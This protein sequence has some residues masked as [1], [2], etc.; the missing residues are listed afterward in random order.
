MRI[1]ILILT[2]L[3]ASSVLGQSDYK[4]MMNDMQVNFYDVVKE[5]ELY[6]ETH[7]TGKGSG[8]KDYQRW[9][10]DNESKY[11]PS[12]DRSQ[13]DPYFVAN[14]YQDFRK[15]NP[16]PKNFYSNQWR[17]LGPYDANNI[18]SHYSP[19]IGRVECFW[20]NPSDSNH[21]YMG[22]R[23]GG[24]W[25][26]TNE[27]ATWQNTTDFLIASGVYTIAVSP[28]NNDSILIGI[29]NAANNASHG[30]YRSTDGGNTWMVTAFNPTNLGWGGLG[31]NDRIF[32]IVYHP[33]IPNLIF[34]GTSKGIFKSAD[35]LQTWTQLLTSADITDIEFHPTNPDI[36][37]LY[38]DYSSSSNQN[39]VMR[40]TDL[41]LS[42][43]I[44]GTIA[45]NNNAKGFIAVSPLCPD[46]VWF[47]SGNG[48]WKS[49]DSGINFTFLI[50]PDESC[51]GF[52]VSDIN[53]N[54]MIYGY[55]DV[56][57]SFDG[58]TTFNQV[59]AWANS[60]PDGS[61]VHA[62]V[63]TAE[64]LNG[65]YYVGT[66]GYLAKSTDNGINWTRLND[67]TGIRE[68][69]A[70]GISQSDWNV[71]MAGSQDNGTSVRVE[72]G[73]L[74]WN[75]GDGMEAI[76]LPLNPDWMIGSW[77]YGTRNRTKDRGQSRHGIGTP[78]AGS[79]QADWQSPLL[80]NP[81]HQ[82][83]VYH[84]SDSVFVSNTFGGDWEYVGS[85]N[86][87]MIKI[88][89]IAENNTALMVLGRN[90]NLYLSQDTGATYTSISAGLPGYTITDVAFDPSDDN[91]L[92]VVYNR[93]Q[94]D[95]KKVYVSHDLGATWTNITSN[96]SNMPIRSV[97]IDHTSQSNIYLGAEIGVF[98]MSMDSTN[99]N[100][101]NT[102]LPNTTA[103]DLE[104]QYGT[105][106]LRAATWGRGLWEYSLVGRNDYPS[107]VT[108][109]ITD[110][111]TDIHP[112][113]NFDQFVTSVVS[114]D[115]VLSSVFVKWSANN[116]SL[117]NTITMINTQDS[118]W[119]S[120]THIPNYPEGTNI[121]FK[122]F[123]IGENSDT[124][125][126]Y[127][128]MYTV[129]H[130]EYCESYGN[131]DYNTALTLV[132]FGGIYNSTGKTQPYTDYTATDSATVEIGSSYN[133]NVNLNT[134]GNYTIYSKAWIDWNRDGDFGDAGEEYDLGSAVNTANGPTS[135]SPFSVVV[136][137]YAHLGKTTMRV[138]A[139][140]NSSPVVCATGFN[141]EVEDYSI[142]ITCQSTPTSMV[143][144]ACGAYTT[145]SGNNTYYSSG[146]IADTLLALNGCDSILSIDLTIVDIDTSLTWSLLTLTANA[147]GAQYQWIDCDNGNAWISG[148]TAQS[149]APTIIG[150][151][152]VIISQ[153][154]CTDTSTCYNVPLVSI[155]E[156]PLKDICRIFPNPTNSNF[157]IDLG[158]VQAEIYV[159]IADLSGKVIFTFRESGVRSIP[160]QT[161]IPAGVYFVSLKSGEDWA[162]LR[163]LVE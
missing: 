112:R 15:N 71:Q 163:L 69:Y 91:T 145:P 3:I 98:Y 134:D 147:A 152:A 48:V 76:V 129:R 107:I 41:G 62:D 11:Y 142:L 78:Q 88:A 136:P 157:T 5:A 105:N 28:T 45:G 72:Q 44:S 32:K 85:P 99:W 119:V 13:V 21:I 106:V 120:Q 1:S 116:Q 84:F 26:T 108:T 82:M 18:T 17:D 143:A 20:V 10:A 74:E 59:T 66:D 131:M 151:Y 123:A 14:A 160:V 128:F 113:A 4:Q 137:L 102:G 126:T 146:M 141:G 8:F 53:I 114:Y 132:D 125:E 117:S 29:Q 158:S 94:N 95:G 22:S 51:Q 31:T 27:G 37:Y 140:Y 38:D 56:E 87:G 115:G 50:N 130:F 138:I 43:S 65:V 70:V 75:G 57:A 96:L 97:V 92:V 111:P 67:G 19:G 124:T 16:A 109:A 162:V 49:T 80:F 2:L 93:Y 6:F 7:D 24:F 121:Y 9:K 110:P 154:S 42:Y 12:G 54:S 159:E 89:A 155:D 139:K 83:K 39:A 148:A 23:S 127:R 135:L 64:C 86:V 60:S 63:R 55:V 153:N 61:Y 33:T 46:C 34:I 36:I 30:I 118:T 47:A 58:G 52:A 161:K 73:W 68:F 103:R 100:L 101:Y 156:N 79:D 90:A 104:I 35:N 144:T 149:F 25:K 40:S 81:N 77:Q 133:L 122:V 150:N